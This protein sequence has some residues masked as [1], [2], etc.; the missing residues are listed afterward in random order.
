[1][2]ATL[3]PGALLSECDLPFVWV[4]AEGKSATLFRLDGTSSLL[5]K[6]SSTLTWHALLAGTWRSRSKEPGVR[7]A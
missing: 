4:T 2:E 7:Y 1:M 6:S 3:K 5:R